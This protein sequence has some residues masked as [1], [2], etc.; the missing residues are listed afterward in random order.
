MIL[1]LMKF[2]TQRDQNIT[3]R[4][5]RNK[6]P[7]FPID[8]RMSDLHPLHLESEL[9]DICHAALLLLL[10]LLLDLLHPGNTMLFAVAVDQTCAVIGSLR[11]RYFDHVNAVGSKHQHPLTQALMR[12]KSAHFTGP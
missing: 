11:S 6:S 1:L 9:D 12:Q 3:P 2:T 10:L 8:R 5:M 4:L 7:W